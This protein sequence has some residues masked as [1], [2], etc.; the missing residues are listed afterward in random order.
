MKLIQQ[1]MRYQDR[2]TVFHDKKQFSDDPCKPEDIVV[3][4]GPANQRVIKAIVRNINECATPKLSIVP[5][6]GKT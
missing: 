3:L 4:S 6:R 2:D 1:V 5:N